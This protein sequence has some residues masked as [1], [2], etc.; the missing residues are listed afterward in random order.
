MLQRGSCVIVA[1][2][3]VHIGSQSY[4]TMSMAGVDVLHQFHK[5]EAL[6]FSPITALPPPPPPPELWTLVYSFFFFFI[7]SSN[8]R[9]KER[10]VVVPIISNGRILIPRYLSEA[11]GNRSTS[12]HPFSIIVRM[13]IRT[14]WNFL[15][16]WNGLT[17]LRSM[18]HLPS[19]ECFHCS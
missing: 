10:L 15:A 16:T 14:G 6:G 8:D 7:K 11:G 18:T 4:L 17:K 5:N 3:S 19:Y 13:H 1:P 9:K 12:S 2:V